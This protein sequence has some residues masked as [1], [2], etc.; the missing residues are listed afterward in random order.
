MAIPV[1]VR[2]SIRDMGRELDIGKM[3]AHHLK[4]EGD[5][6]KHSSS[7]KPALMEENKLERV[8]WCLDQ[9]DPDTSQYSEMLDMVHVDEKWF[10][11][12]EITKSC[13]LIAGEEDPYCTCRHKNH[14]PR[15]MFLAA[16]AW[17]HYDHH[18]Q[19]MWDG[20]IG[21]WECINYVAAHRSSRNRPAGTIEPKPYNIDGP[22]YMD[23]I[24]NK[25]VLLAIALKCP[26]LMKSKPIFIHHDNALP[27]CTVFSSL[28]A[29]IEKTQSL[30]SMSTSLSSH[31]TAQI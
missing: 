15:I 30:A 27:H 8:G 1:L 16:T 26:L 5:L 20:K 17:P 12:M 7:I 6:Q 13:Y 24:L 2:R 28:P 9:I 10:N 18:T 23:L 14:I 22:R 31:Q 4:M 3:T 29:L 21:I 25:V 11:L 19:M